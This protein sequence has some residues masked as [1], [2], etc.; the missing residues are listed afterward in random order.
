[1][2]VVHSRKDERCHSRIPQE[3]FKLTEY[4]TMHG[5]VLVIYK[6]TNHSLHVLFSMAMACITLEGG[7]RE[8]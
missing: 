1:M 5:E 7:Y 6:A 3:D 8:Y 2:H 4:L